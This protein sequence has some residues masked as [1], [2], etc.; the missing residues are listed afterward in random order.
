MR[1]CCKVLST[2]SAATPACHQWPAPWRGGQRLAALAPR[3]GGDG[4]SPAGPPACAS[5]CDAAACGCHAEAAPQAWLRACRRA[6]QAA[7]GVSA[8]AVARAC[9]TRSLPVCKCKCACKLALEQ[10]STAAGRPRTSSCQVVRQALPAR[11]RR[12]RQCQQR[13]P[14]PPQPRM[15]AERTA[16]NSLCVFRRCPASCCCQPSRGKRGR[17]SCAQQQACAGSSKG[18]CGACRPSRRAGGGRM[19]R[20]GMLA[21]MRCMHARAMDAAYRWAGRSTAHRR[22]PSHGS[23]SSI[24]SAAPPPG[25]ACSANGV[26]HAPPPA[27]T[28]NSG[29][30]T[31][32]IVHR[33]HAGLHAPRTMHATA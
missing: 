31:S 10:H 22:G 7:Q 30:M 9:C 13:L 18:S 4:G 26:C 33:M 3:R 19:W 5:R 11:L 15:A 24:V 1:C 23:C 27:T 16:R 32:S 25:S 21:R 28:G 8:C 12:T 17:R 14:G 29:S 6:R 2:A 20:A